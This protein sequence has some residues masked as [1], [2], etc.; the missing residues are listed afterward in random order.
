MPV[1]EQFKAPFEFQQ[2]YHILFRSIDG[3]PLF[4]TD[5]EHLFF[6]EKWKRFTDPVFDTWAYSLLDNHTHFII[7]VKQQ[8]EII[9]LLRA[10]TGDETTKAIKE[11]LDKKKSLI[12][13]VIERQINSFMVSYANTYNNFIHRKGGLFQQP[14]RRSAIA[15]DAHLQQAIVYVHA[16]A[17]KH[18]LQNDFKLHPQNSYHTIVEGNNAIINTEAV[19]NFF[20]GIDKF[21]SIHSEQVAYFY[22]HQ[23]PNSK[24]EIDS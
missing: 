21:I 3:I 13:P 14:F 17:Q 15:G 6:L 22:K 2:H 11:F 9:Q 10:L 4:K 7:Q 23:W 8:V 12:G 5:K 19:R 1:P 24:V 16:N 20:G 18:G